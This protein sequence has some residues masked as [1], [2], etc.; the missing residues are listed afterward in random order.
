MELHQWLDLEV[1]TC[2]QN[3]STMA[4]TIGSL[5]IEFK[6]HLVFIRVVHGI[7]PRPQACGKSH[8]GVQAIK[9]QIW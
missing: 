6:I 5:R 1:S 9:D 3:T 4:A 7:L 2:S 8:I